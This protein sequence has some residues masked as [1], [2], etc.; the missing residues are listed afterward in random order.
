MLAFMKNMM[1]QEGGNHPPKE[2]PEPHADTPE[3]QADN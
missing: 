3:Y 2:N 1:L